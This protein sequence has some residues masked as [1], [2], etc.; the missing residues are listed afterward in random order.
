M[1]I[2]PESAAGKVS[3]G[4]LPDLKLHISLTLFAYQ[5][6]L[7]ILVNYKLG[8]LFILFYSSC[9]LIIYNSC[10]KSKAGNQR[11]FLV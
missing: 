5:I 11:N 9:L 2:R 4:W 10:P 8:N 3:C 1:D 7:N 6:N